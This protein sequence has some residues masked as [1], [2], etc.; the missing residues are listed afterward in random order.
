MANVI[1]VQTRFVSIYLCN[2]HKYYLLILVTKFC[3]QEEEEK[4]NTKRIAV[5]FATPTNM[6]V[7][8]H[9]TSAS[10]VNC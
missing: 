2:S 6:S 9:E 7:N 4:K 3:K 10:I 5:R 8:L 1:Y